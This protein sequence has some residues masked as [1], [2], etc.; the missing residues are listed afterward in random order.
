MYREDT[1]PEADEE[2]SLKI[3]AHYTVYFILFSMIAIDL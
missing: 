3:T 1:S 2:T